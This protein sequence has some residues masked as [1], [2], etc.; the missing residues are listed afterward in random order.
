MF[1]SI[2]LNVQNIL[3]KLYKVCLKNLI[4]VSNKLN[5]FQLSLRKHFW[6]VIYSMHLLI[7]FFHKN[8]HALYRKSIKVPPSCFNLNIQHTQHVHTH[9]QYIYIRIYIYILNIKILFLLFV[10]VDFFFFF[11]HNAHLSVLEHIDLSMVF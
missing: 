3:G 7:Y 2:I 5:L 8:K 1:V 9:T 6:F 4:V 10:I 11:W